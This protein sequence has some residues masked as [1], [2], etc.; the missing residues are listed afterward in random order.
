MRT[1]T[2]GFIAKVL[3]L[4]LIVGLLPTLAL[5]TG[6]DHTITAEAATGGHVSIYYLLD[7][8][9][10]VRWTTLTANEAYTACVH[11]LYLHGRQ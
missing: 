7:D 1:N 10:E 2:R 8:D 9:A 4:C 5:A 11:R 6:T 3:V